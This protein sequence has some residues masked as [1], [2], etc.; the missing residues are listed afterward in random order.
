MSDDAE[1]KEYQAQAADE[2]N[3]T[4]DVRSTGDNRFEALAFPMPGKPPSSTT[5]RPICTRPTA[6]EA[7]RDAV[8]ILRRSATH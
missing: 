8:E 6:V 3:V 1:I 7:A 2:F 5:G 4:I